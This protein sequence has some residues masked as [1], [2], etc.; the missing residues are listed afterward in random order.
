M[1]CF[2]DLII[3]SFLWKKR[4]CL[5][6]SVHQAPILNDTL[7]DFSRFGSIWTWN[8]LSGNVFFRWLT[9]S[10]PLTRIPAL[11]RCNNVRRVAL[12][13]LPWELLPVIASI[14][15]DSFS[16]LPISIFVNVPL[17][18]LINGFDRWQFR[19]R[20]NAA[21]F[22]ISKLFSYN[23]LISTEQLSYHFFITYSLFQSS[24]G[25]FQFSLKYFQFA[26]KVY[27]LVPLCSLFSQIS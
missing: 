21:G 6:C 12:T 11:L 18:I 15:D 14:F 16:S 8:S 27:T 1:I 17:F 24:L 4:N 5:T 20:G 2:T 26:F 13:K 23:V 19:Q 22:L 3:W 9:T 10:S 7:L 25:I